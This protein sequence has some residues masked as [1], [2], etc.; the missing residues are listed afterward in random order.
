MEYLDFDITIKPTD[1]S[2]YEVSVRSPGGQRDF[3]MHFPFDDQALR[4]QLEALEVALLR[5]RAKSRRVV[6]REEQTV[7]GFGRALFGALIGKVSDLY[8]LSHQQAGEDKGLRVVL[9]INDPR[10]AAVPW[11]F[12]Y[13]PEQREYVCLS[14]HTPIV[15]YPDQASP[16]NPISVRPPLRILGMAVSPKGLPRLDLEREK[17][18]ME[19]AV[20]PLAR[21][22]ELKWL[23]GQTSQDLQNAISS[24]TWHVFHFIGHGEYSEETDEGCVILADEEGR[25]ERL[26]ALNLARVLQHKPLKMVV[27]NACEGARG[28]GKDALS[29][30]ASPL[31]LRGVQAVLAMQYEIGDDAAIEFSRA[32]YGAICRGVPIEEA[33]AEARISIAI[34]NSVEWGTPVLHLRAES[35]RLFDINL[36]GERLAAMLTQARAHIAE[37]DWASAIANLQVIVAADP[38]NAAA[39]AELERASA[40]QQ[41]DL[42]YEEGRSRFEAGRVKSA[43]K[44][45]QQVQAKEGN[46]RDTEELLRRAEEKLNERRAAMLLRKAEDCINLGQLDGAAENLTAALEL[47]PGH[48]AVSARLDFVRKRQEVAALYESGVRHRAAGRT[49][50][51]LGDL[52]R[53]Q[54]I[55]PGYK[56]LSAVV[57]AMDAEEARRIRGRIKAFL[58]WFV[59]ARRRV[60]V[61][62]VAAFALA[63]VATVYGGILLKRYIWPPLYTRPFSDPFTATADN[64]PDTSVW[65]YPRGLWTLEPGRDGVRN[66]ALQVTKTGNGF[67]KGKVFGDFNA[68]FSVQYKS[69]TRAA[70]LLRAWPDGS[71]GYYGYYFELVKTDDRFILKSEVRRRFFGSMPLDSGQ[72]VGIKEYGAQPD[73]NILVKVEAKG[74][75][76]SYDF[77]LQ[78]TDPYDERPDTNGGFPIHVEDE[79]SYYSEGLFGLAG[80]DDESQVLYE[81]VSVIPTAPR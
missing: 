62:T 61:A 68:E 42:L 33:L 28:G 80:T 58:N 24:G 2:D 9:H 17:K 79:N 27:L 45:L 8:K 32:F 72:L 81:S 23:Q 71:G 63:L 41:L 30:T 75:K 78:S 51:A 21:L 73:D 6:S 47:R 53:A 50:E 13:D 66:R 67:V 15:R 18:R 38:A 54:L 16:V 59:A 44:L 36:G 37:G 74:N 35:G 40:R 29:S 20:R 1:G 12:L 55:D 14:R 4:A 22:V 7:E 25:P 57:A 48:E 34:G 56:D 49:P 70:W 31:L 64:R 60:Q 26:N 43:L 10:L 3:P 65:D 46:Y 11:E 76:F 19:D 77:S 39:A 5:S 69:G 52:R